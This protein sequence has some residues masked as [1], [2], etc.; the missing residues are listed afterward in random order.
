[1]GLRARVSVDEMFADDPW[2]VP[3]LGGAAESA[4]RQPWGVKTDVS[5]PI[6]SFFVFGSPPPM[7]FFFRL[8]VFFSFMMI[9]LVHFP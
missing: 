3:A 1:V 9:G 7:F 5:A 2:S 6:F 4:G 8:G